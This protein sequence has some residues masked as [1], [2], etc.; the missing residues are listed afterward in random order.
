MQKWVSNIFS[1]NKL[2]QLFFVLLVF[3]FSNCQN[4]HN[5]IIGIYKSK[6]IKQ[7]SFL[8]RIKLYINKESI[9]TGQTLVLMQDSVFYLQTCGNHVSGKW[10]IRTGDTLLLFCE[11]NR[12]R[13]DSLNKIEKSSCGFD[14]SKYYVHDGIL[15]SWFYIGGVKTYDRLQKVGVN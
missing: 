4:I 2:K 12:L 15:E 1:C 13:N 5:D 7:Y 14:P 3:I 8:D 9:I 6:N 11:R 10:R